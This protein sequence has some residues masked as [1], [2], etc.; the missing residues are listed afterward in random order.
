M[1]SEFNYSNIEYCNSMRAFR[2]KLKNMPLGHEFMLI[3]NFYTPF[4]IIGKGGMVFK[5]SKSALSKKE[6]REFRRLLKTNKIEK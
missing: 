1:K 6:I 4:D 5:L 3:H 2:R